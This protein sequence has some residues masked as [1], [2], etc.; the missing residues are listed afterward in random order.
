[1][2]QYVPYLAALITS[3]WSLSLPRGRD[4]AVPIALIPWWALEVDFGISLKIN[5][6][7]MLIVCL[8]HFFSSTFSFRE[9]P[10]RV[11]LLIYIILSLVI[12]VVTIDYGPEVPQFANG[13]PMRNG[14]GRVL[15]QLIKLAFLFGFLACIISNRHRVSPIALMR[16]YVASCVILSLLGIVQFL[17]FLGSG[18]DICPIGVFHSDTGR[19]G[20]VSIQGSNFIRISSLGGEPKGFGLALSVA[21]SVLVVFARQFGLSQFRYRMEVGILAFTLLMTSST[22]AYIT[23]L[24]GASFLLVF[25]R[26]PSPF[27]RWQVNTVMVLLAMS[28]SGLFYGLAVFTDTLAPPKYRTM[29]SFLDNIIYKVTDRV[30]LDDSDAVIME[31]LVDQPFDLIFGR[32]LGVS[33]HYSHKFIPWYNEFYMKGAIIVP[34]SGVTEYVSN[35]GLIGLWCMTLAFAGC[36][37]AYNNVNTNDMSRKMISDIQALAF[38]LFAALML[39]LYSIEATW[40]V[41]TCVHLM[42]HSSR[43]KSTGE[44]PIGKA[45]QRT[46]FR[47]FP[48]PHPRRVAA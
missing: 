36:I 4:L 2:I 5:E 24:V 32:G 13:A 34:K 22:S 47:N 29:T 18:T 6:L 15:S 7:L 45:D 27:T 1:M 16:A 33:H 37:P 21:V 48:P 9:M 23:V 40:V 8:K 28:F 25:S 14:Y 3:A 41:F 46:T 19:S 20:F 39:R 38:G 35:S 12:A 10:G 31:S 42:Q 44:M 26:R 17:V 43:R 11:P 30:Q